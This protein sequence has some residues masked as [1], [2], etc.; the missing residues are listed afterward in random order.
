MDGLQADGLQADGLQA[1]GL[2]ADG[3]QALVERL[4]R[5]TND[6]DIDALVACFAKDYV[7]ET[8][9]HPER[10]FVGN[11]QVRSNWEQIF[12]FV[13]DVRAEVV[14]L[15]VDRDTA[16]TEWEMTG[17]RRDGTAHRMRGVIL[18][19]VRDGVAQWARFYLEPLDESATTVDAAVREQ[20][21]RK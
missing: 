2:Q 9:T 7:N 5:A 17:T 1:D 16:W 19:G 6:H 8:P 3:P 10:G 14:R 20:V 21:V 4:V 15:A 11:D 13:P 12:T 18:F